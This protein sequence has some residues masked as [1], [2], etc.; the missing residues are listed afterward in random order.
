GGEVGEA[1]RDPVRLS[2]QPGDQEGDHDEPEQPPSRSRRAESPAPRPATPHRGG[3][4]YSGALLTS[5]FAQLTKTVS[6]SMS[7]WSTTVVGSM[8][9]LPKI[10]GPVSTIR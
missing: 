7:T 4:V 3:G 8:T 10:H 1:G 5:S 2:A 9:F 6:V